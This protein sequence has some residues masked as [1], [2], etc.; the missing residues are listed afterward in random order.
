MRGTIKK[1]DPVRKFGPKMVP[2]FSRLFDNLV[3]FLSSPWFTDQAHF[4]TGILDPR[5]DHLIMDQNHGPGH[6][7]TDHGRLY[8]FLIHRQGLLIS[9]HGLDQIKYGPKFGPPY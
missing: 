8:L 9:G 7:I 5:M 4:W 1:S 6:L 3:R 2:N